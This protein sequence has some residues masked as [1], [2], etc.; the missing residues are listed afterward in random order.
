MK[1]MNMKFIAIAVAVIILLLGGGLFLYSK[2]SSSNPTGKTS[3]QT[4]VSPTTTTSQNGSLLDIFSSGKTQKCDFSYK[5]EDGT[6]T[7]GA[8]YISANKVRGSLDIT[9]NGKLSTMNILRDGDTNYMWGSALPTGIKM[10]LSANDF[11]TKINTTSATNPNQKMDFKCVP[12]T[13][14]QSLFI[15]P[16]DVKF[17]DLSNMTVSKTPAANATQTPSSD[18][19]VCNSLTGNAKIACRT[20]LH[21]Q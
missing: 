13:V 1:T 11:A 20:G 6:S 18:C 5:A 21:C 12:W 10:T 15:V 14:D 7:K 3:T 4:A 2:N 9:T 19:S 16:A 17:T 8:F